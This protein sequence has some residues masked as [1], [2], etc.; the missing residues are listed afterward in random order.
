M[1]TNLIY[2]FIIPFS[3]YIYYLIKY[4]IQKFD[5]KVFLYELKKEKMSILPKE[6]LNIILE[7]DGRI[8]YR[9]GKYINCLNI[10]DDRYNIIKP[11]INQKIEILK[12]IEFDNNTN[13][14]YF[15]INFDTYGTIGLV[16]DYN[17][18]YDN[19]FEICYFDW[20]QTDNIIQIRT[21]I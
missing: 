21:Y 3:Y 20:S 4:L 14:F 15:E 17:F 1:I 18:S 5:N 19:I 7:F 9:N 16:Y 10:D 13:G 11:I 6:I 2:Y 8:K 12:N